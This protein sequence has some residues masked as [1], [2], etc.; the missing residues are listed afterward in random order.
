MKTTPLHL[1]IALLVLMMGAR[2]SSES[3]GLTGGE[4]PTP[5]T[6]TIRVAVMSGGGSPISA[7]ATV[8]L[9]GPTERTTT[10]AIGATLTVTDLPPGTYT[11]VATVSS[12]IDCQSA[13]ANLGAGET[14][15]AQITCTRRIGTITGTVSGG[16]MPI[17]GATVKLSGPTSNAIKTTGP[18]GTFTFVAAVGENTLTTLHQGFVCPV[19]AVMVE[20]NQTMTAEISCAPK[21]TGSITG[22]VVFGPDD[23]FGIQFVL[24]TLT[25]PVTRTATTYDYRGSFTFD[26]LTPGTYTLAATVSGMDCPAVSADVQAAQTTALFIRCTPRPLIGSEIE[27][28]WWYSRQLDSQTGSCPPPLP[29]PQELGGSMTFNPSNNTVAIVGLDPDLTIVGAYDKNSGLYMGTGKAV[30]GDG[31]SIQT[32][33]T[34]EFGSCWDWECLVPSVSGVMTRRH[35]DSSGTLVCTETYRAGGT[36]SWDY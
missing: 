28:S 35:R 16:G 34:A 36:H 3:S 2:C 32:D 33:M 1:A 21:T 8:R 4:E 29:D 14:T 17:R 25:G 7:T 26:D 19:R 15:T 18:D 27:G 23:G 5:T 31:S 10:G 13:S 22:R 11:L 12:F 9:T 30:L 20:L 6:G 24:A